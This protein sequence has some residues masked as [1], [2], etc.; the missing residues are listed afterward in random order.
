M[1][2]N[3]CG[4]QKLLLQLRILFYP[5]FSSMSTFSEKVFSK[6]SRSQQDVR[7]SDPFQRTNESKPMTFRMAGNLRTMSF[8]ARMSIVFGIG[9]GFGTV[10]EVF[11]CKTHLYEIVGM[12]KELRRHEIDEFVVKFRSDMEKW[13]EE[14]LKRAEIANSK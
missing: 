1:V 6:W 5:A 4:A 12:K 8:P 2:A 10:I 9:F 14:D 3:F 13:Q 7:R 11:A